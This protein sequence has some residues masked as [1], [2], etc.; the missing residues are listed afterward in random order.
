MSANARG[1]KVEM[2]QQ[3]ITARQDEL[4]RVADILAKSARK[5]TR[6]A[7]INRGA[8]IF[9]GACATTQGA[10]EKAFDG[11]AP[12][13]FVVFTLLGVIITTIAGIEAAFKFEAKGAEL[14]LLAASCH[15]TVRTTDATWLRQVAIA[16]T[17][18]EK[19]AGSLSLIELQD[20]KL[21]EIQ[22]KAATSGVNLTLEIRNL[23]RAGEFWDSEEPRPE[24]WAYAAPPE[25][26]E[27]NPQ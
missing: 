25:R 15:S 11:Y 12:Y 4:Q 21:S 23:S 8:L 19:I 18:E 17:P 20:T 2:L 5:S 1:T 27:G 16:S 22:E 24:G 26:P 7:S 14:N 10:W 9:F 6:Y 13:Q 3:G